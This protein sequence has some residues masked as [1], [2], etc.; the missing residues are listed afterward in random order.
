MLKIISI[1][2]VGHTIK[3]L[4][5]QQMATDS[6]SHIGADDEMGLINQWTASSLTDKSPSE[7]PRVASRWAE[8]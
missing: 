5:P 6:Q 8:S 4:T 3:Y 7:T 2:E 1:L